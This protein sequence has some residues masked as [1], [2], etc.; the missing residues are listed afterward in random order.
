MN[1]NELSQRLQMVGELVPENARLADIGSD[2]AYLPVHL[3]LEGAI[4]YAV[5]G[6]VVKGPFLSAQKQVAQNG[7]E[8]KIT[9]RLAD[10]LAAL[11]A[12]DKI[13]TIT[14]C[15]MGGSLIRDILEAGRL[16]GKLTGKETLILQPNVGEAALRT[17]LFAQGY[18]ITAEKILEE[19]GKIYEIIKAEKAA[20][21]VVYSE[22]ELYFGPF[23]LRE[24]SESF[25]KK[26]R[27]ELQQQ[28]AVLEQL[29]AAKAGGE[30]RKITVE[31]T[32]AMIREVLA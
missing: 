15:G 10:G 26:W 8:Q 23:L 18:R 17:W 3:M 29:K 12:D 22:A 14:I 28:E 21:P 4:A 13:D 24:K 5:A 27:R 16:T 19:K 31:K 1:A 11:E 6:E 9:V 2:H 25:I 32:A 30:N 7:L 20:E